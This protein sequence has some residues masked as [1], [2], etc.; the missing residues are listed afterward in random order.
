MDPLI[1][2]AMAACLRLS[3][4]GTFDNGLEDC[5]KIA[6]AYNDQAEDLPTQRAPFPAFQNTPSHQADLDTVK[7][8]AAKLP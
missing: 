4:G 7:N 1:A 6:V 5:E 3:N 2:A 8:A